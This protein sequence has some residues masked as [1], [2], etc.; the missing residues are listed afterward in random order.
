MYLR[1]TRIYL[2]RTRTI[3]RKDYDIA[4]GR[5]TIEVGSVSNL[6]GR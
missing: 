3:A 2:A 5:A 6:G 4:I 1:I